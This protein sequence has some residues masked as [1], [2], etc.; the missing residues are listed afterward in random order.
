VPFG[1]VEWLPSLEFKGHIFSEVRIGKASYME[2][3]KNNFFQ[4]LI[5][6]L[7]LISCFQR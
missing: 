6:T 3:D 7:F 4:D 5:S 1:A 2:I